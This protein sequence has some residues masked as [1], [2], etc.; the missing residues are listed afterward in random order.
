[1]AVTYEQAGIAEFIDQTWGSIS[2]IQDG[3]HRSIFKMVW[4]QPAPFSFSEM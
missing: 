1:M 3:F 2:S 4:L